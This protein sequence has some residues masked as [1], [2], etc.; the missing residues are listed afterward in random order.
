MRLGNLAVDYLLDRKIHHRMTV[1]PEGLSDPLKD[2]AL[3]RILL[4]VTK[5]HTALG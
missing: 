4:R 1:L 5:K 3:S 2:S